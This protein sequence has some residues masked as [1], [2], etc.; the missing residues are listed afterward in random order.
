M[1][2]DT[3]GIAQIPPTLLLCGTKK[4]VTNKTWA[5]VSI[6]ADPTTQM[7]TLNVATNDRTLTGS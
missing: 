2:T 4:Y 1:H 5:T 3:Q 6:P 7:L